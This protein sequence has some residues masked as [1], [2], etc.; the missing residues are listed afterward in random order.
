MKERHWTTK[1][2]ELICAERDALQRSVDLADIT[3]NDMTHQRDRYKA[4]VRN[5]LGLINIVCD[6]RNR[7]REALEKA[8]L[9]LMEA[10]KRQR[11]AALAPNTEGEGT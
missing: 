5:V 10:V 6:E 2:V 4:E 3:L 7:Y 9:A 1:H 11:S 8:N